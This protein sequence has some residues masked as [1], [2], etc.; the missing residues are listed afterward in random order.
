MFGIIYIERV[1][2]E[3]YKMN[4]WIAITKE[5]PKENKTKGYGLCNVLVTHRYA[6]ILRTGIAIFSNGKFYTINHKKPDE[7]VTAWM[8][9][10]EPYKE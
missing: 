4:E 7:T 1:R 3:R 2:K 8:P 10:P 5:L 9:L 6:G